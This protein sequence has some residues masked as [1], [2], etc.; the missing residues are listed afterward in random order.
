MAAG[1]TVVVT[2]AAGGTGHFGVQL[3]LLAGCHVIATCGGEKKAEKLRQIGCHR[4]VDHQKE[5]RKALGG[6][7]WARA[8]IKENLFILGVF[9]M[10]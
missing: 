3:A 1:E 10:V 4:V 8:F 5:V 9:G 2:A 6:V 7:F